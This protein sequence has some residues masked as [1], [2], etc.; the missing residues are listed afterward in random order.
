[1][2]EG[3]ASWI[4]GKEYGSY[5]NEERLGG[6]GPLR[7][8][9]D[10]WLTSGLAYIAQCSHGRRGHCEGKT[11]SDCFAFTVSWRALSCV[12]WLYGES[13]KRCRPPLLPVVTRLLG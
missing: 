9:I 3:L 7:C 1:M 8:D 13:A 10:V 6:G 4:F 5:I 2:T 12:S 11:P